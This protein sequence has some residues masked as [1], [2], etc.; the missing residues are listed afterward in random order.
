[1]CVCVSLCVNYFFINGPEVDK[2]QKF[3]AHTFLKIILFIVD[4]NNQSVRFYF[5]T[6]RQLDITGTT[7]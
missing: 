4:L 6:Q 5:C 2:R 1:M 7:D 3:R